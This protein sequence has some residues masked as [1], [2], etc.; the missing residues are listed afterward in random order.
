MVYFE[1]ILGLGFLM[2]GLLSVSSYSN[3]LVDYRIPWFYRELEP[4]QKRWGKYVGT[5]LHI[6]GYVVAPV[7]FGILLLS[8]MV[9]P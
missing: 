5:I 1:N 6:I 3:E 7:G 8:G 2:L 4:M 9:F